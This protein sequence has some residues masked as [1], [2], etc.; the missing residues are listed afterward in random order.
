M[1]RF[2]QALPITAREPSPLQFPAQ[3]PPGEL[4]NQPG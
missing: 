4:F 3:P 2:G 1:Y